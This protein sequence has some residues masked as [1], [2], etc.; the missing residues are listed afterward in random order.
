VAFRASSNPEASALELCERL[1]KNDFVKEALADAL[2]RFLFLCSDD[3]GFPE[4]AERME[5]EGALDSEGFD[6]FL[7]FLTARAE[8]AEELRRTSI[9][10][11]K[12]G[13]SQP[14]NSSAERG[15][16]LSPRDSSFASY[17]ETKQ[18]FRFL[19]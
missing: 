2:T 13:I 4:R 17:P 6:G 16:H 7:N 9:D 3:P 8:R 19:R 15:Q 10:E 1:W 14:P 5:R 11:K 12:G 18:V